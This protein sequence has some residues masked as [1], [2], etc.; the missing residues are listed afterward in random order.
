[1][2]GISSFDNEGRRVS[3]IDIGFLSVMPAEDDR[4]S[5]MG[6]DIISDGPSSPCGIDDENWWGNRVGVG[7]TGAAAPATA[8]LAC[9]VYYFNI[10]S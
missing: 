3:S 8:A 10:P 9:R 6:V 5:K 1:M 2:L 4:L 7:K